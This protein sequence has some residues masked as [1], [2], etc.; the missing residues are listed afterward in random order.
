M[1][2]CNDCD[3]NGDCGTSGL[4]APRYRELKSLS[5]TAHNGQDAVPG[6]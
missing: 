1:K 5:G 2:D 3:L 4:S 6:G